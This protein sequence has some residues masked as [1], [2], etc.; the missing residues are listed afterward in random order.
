M[1]RARSDYVFVPTDH[2]IQTTDGSG[3]HSSINYH[4]VANNLTNMSANMSANLSSDIDPEYLDSNITS[5][6]DNI[7]VPDPSTW[8]QFFDPIIPEKPYDNYP[9]GYNSL[10]IDSGLQS[11]TSFDVTPDPLYQSLSY[12]QLHN[13]N[14]SRSSTLITENKYT[15]NGEKVGTIYFYQQGTYP[16]AIG[17]LTLNDLGQ[18][19]PFIVHHQICQTIEDEFNK[20]LFSLLDNGEKQNPK[21][22]LNWQPLS[23]Y[24]AYTNIKNQD[25]SCLE[26]IPHTSCFGKINMRVK[27]AWA[28]LPNKKKP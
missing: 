5:V 23:I 3:N 16:V 14:L 26:N 17:K 18:L 22:S 20:E 6:L 15:E 10:Q 19:N 12:F 11:T 8:S 27:R 9:Y 2:S 13:F 24:S 7:D 28:R 25:L 4:P 1:K 21:G